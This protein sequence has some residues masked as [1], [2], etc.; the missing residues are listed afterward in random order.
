MTFGKSLQQPHRTLEHSGA[1]QFIFSWNIKRNQTR[2]NN[3]TRPPVIRT[4]WVT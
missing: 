1:L 4:M 3:G 2:S